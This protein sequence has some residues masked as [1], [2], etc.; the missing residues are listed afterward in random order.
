[1][2]TITH[3]RGRSAPRVLDGTSET[4][5]HPIIAEYAARDLRDRRLTHATT[6]RRVARASAVRGAG[7]RSRQAARLVA[8]ARRLDP[9]VEGREVA[10]R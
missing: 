10:T 9:N 3:F 6:R 8:L 7:W 4:Q 1:M 2:T 5:M